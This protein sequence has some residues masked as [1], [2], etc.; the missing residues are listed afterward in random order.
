LVKPK[1]SSFHQRL[2]EAGEKIF[3]Y[4]KK[5]E[6]TWNMGQDHRKKTEQGT[7]KLT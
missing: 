3:G 7:D 5:E 4:V 2:R 1:L 6:R